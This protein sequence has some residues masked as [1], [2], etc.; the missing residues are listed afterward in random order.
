MK[1]GKLF[2]VAPNA[3]IPNRSNMEYRMIIEGEHIPS[4]TVPMQLR[5]SEA[6][7]IVVHRW[8]FS[9]YFSLLRNYG[10]RPDYP[11]FRGFAIVPVN[12]SPNAKIVIS[13]R[14]AAANQGSM[15]PIPRFRKA[16]PYPIVTYNPPTY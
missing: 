13:R 15:R 3:R 11:I 14:G 16:L 2:P 7:P 10:L 12:S 8:Q 6:Q 5:Q 4:A 9:R 1:N